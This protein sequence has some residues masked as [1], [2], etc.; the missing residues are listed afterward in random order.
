VT[1]LSDVDAN[2][3]IENIIAEYEVWFGRKIKPLEVA[4]LLQLNLKRVT[5]KFVETHVAGNDGVQT[6]EILR[7]IEKSYGKKE[8][9]DQDRQRGKGSS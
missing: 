6:H 3:R 2:Q 8:Q 5:D 7:F 9:D 4:E 1:K